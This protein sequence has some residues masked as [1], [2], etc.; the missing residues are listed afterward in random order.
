MKRISEKTNAT[1]AR[2]Y[3]RRASA[4][5][6]TKFAYVFVCILVYCNDNA[7][8][9]SEEKAGGVTGLSPTPK[10]EQR[11]AAGAPL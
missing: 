11:T 1:T 10:N 8:P 4:H 7:P 5:S 3:I 2:T 9:L 6:Y